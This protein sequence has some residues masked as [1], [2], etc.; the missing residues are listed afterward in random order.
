MAVGTCVFVGGEV[1]VNVGCTKL[2]GGVL[3]GTKA[4]R[5]VVAGVMVGIGTARTAVTVASLESTSAARGR[6]SRITSRMMS[7]E[8]AGTQKGRGSAL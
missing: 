6:S 3:V 5:F 2:G 1:G 8:I 4:G 7:R